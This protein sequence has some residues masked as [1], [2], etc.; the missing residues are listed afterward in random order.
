VLVALGGFFGA[1]ALA[2]LAEYWGHRFMHGGF[3]RKKHAQH[4]RSG[5]GQ[6][7]LREMLGYTRGSFPLLPLGFL[8]STAAGCGFLAGALF[9]SAFAAYSH[10]LQ[11]QFPEC[12]F[13]L[14][15]PVHHLHHAHGMWHHNFG[16]SLDLWDRVFGT[17]QPRLYFRPAR[18]DW[19][20]LLRVKWLG[21]ATPDPADGV[22]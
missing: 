22:D 20:N 10:E 19:R 8:H 11:H 6:G 17:Y 7:L 12:C 3:K 2:S 16:I 15:R 13:W 21:P 9:F 14:R 4:H 1:L 5:V 18:T